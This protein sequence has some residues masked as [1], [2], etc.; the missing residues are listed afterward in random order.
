MG[1]R[2]FLAII[3]FIFCSILVATDAD[4]QGIVLTPTTVVFND[5]DRS[6]DI[7]VANSGTGRT[8]FRVETVFFQMQPNGL[9]TEVETHPANSAV[10]FLRFSPRRFELAP[11]ESQT[12]R[13][14][15]RKPADLP[16]GE[17]RVHLRVINLGQQAEVPRAVAQGQSMPM[18]RIQVARAVRILVR[19]GVREGTATPANLVV[20]PL[21][22][23]EA[24]IEFDMVRQGGV[25]VQ[26]AYEAF[27]RD[28]RSGQVLEALATGPVSIYADLDRRHIQQRARLGNPSAQDICVAFKA[29]ANAPANPDVQCSPLA[30]R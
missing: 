29:S 21:P 28:S 12:I 14:A 3:T 13:L 23:G 10:S 20:R 19:H 22:G 2:R 8:N 9:L 1:Y 6:A 11:G 30:A 16:P 18:V 15:L 25:S 5:R 24:Q 4:A 7:R 27:L 26:G 17:Y